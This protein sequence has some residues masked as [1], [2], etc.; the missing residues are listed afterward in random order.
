MDTRVEPASRF[1]TLKFIAIG[2]EHQLSNH[3]SSIAYLRN[4]QAR[5]RY[6]NTRGDKLPKPHPLEPNTRYPKGDRRA[7]VTY[8]DIEYELLKIEC[9]PMGIV[10]GADEAEVLRRR[11]V[12]EYVYTYTLRGPAGIMT[13]S[14]PMVSPCRP[15]GGGGD[16]GSGLIGRDSSIS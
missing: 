7:R 9:K 1:S 8:Q 14:K 16:F 11:H 6:W 3:T 2:N 5:L 4:G 12:R 10:D 13:V 15:V